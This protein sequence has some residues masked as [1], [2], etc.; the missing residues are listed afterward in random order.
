MRNRRL[1]PLLA[2]ASFAVL[3]AAGCGSTSAAVQVD[4]ESISRRDFEDELEVVYENETF[5]TALF[6]QVGPEQLRGEDAPLGSFTQAYVSGMAFV[7]IQFMVVPGIL[8]AEDLE[9]TDED[10]AGAE[11]DVES[12]VPGAFDDVPQSM[13]DRYVEAFAIFDKLQTELGDEFEPVLMAAIEAA[14]IRVSSRYGTW[15]PDD[16]AVDPPAGPRPAPGRGS[17]TTGIPADGSDLPAG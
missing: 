8:E 9:V 17:S 3:G 4:D 11:D 5:R 13:R 14:D 15:N 7:Q 6:G 10:V 2:A 1:V 12:E 16:L